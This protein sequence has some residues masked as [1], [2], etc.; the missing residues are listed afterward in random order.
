[1]EMT[2]TQHYFIKSFINASL[3]LYKH[4]LIYLLRVNIDIVLQ[5]H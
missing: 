3:R 5:S 1:M 2:S 4:K